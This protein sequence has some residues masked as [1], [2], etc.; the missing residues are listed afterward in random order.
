MAA[1][2]TGSAQLAVLATPFALLVAIA[3]AGEPPALEGDL[4]ARPRPHP[5][6]RPSARDARRRQPR[7]RRARRRSVAGRRAARQRPG[8]DRVLARAR[9]TAGAD[10]RARG[11]ALGRAR[12][13]SR[14]RPRERPAR[15]DDDRRT[16][17]RGGRRKGLR[18]CPTPAQHRRAAPHQAGPGQPGLARARRR[19][20]V[21]RSAPA[22][23]GRPRSQHQLARDRASPHAIR[24][25]PASGAQRGP[26]AVS[27]H[28]RGGATRGRGN[29]RRGGARRRGARLYLSRPARPRGAGQSRRG[30]EMAH[31]QPR[32]AAALSHPRRA[33][34][35]RGAAELP[36]EGGHAPTASAPPGAG[37]GDRADPTAGRARGQARCSNCAPAGTTSPSSRSRRSETLGATTSRVRLWRLQRDAL[38]SRFETLGISV[39]RCEPT[40]AGVELAIEEVIT[41]RRHAR[42]VARVLTTAAGAIAL[43][44][45]AAADHRPL[46]RRR[47][48]PRRC[49]C[50][51]RCSPAAPGRSAS[52]WCSWGRS[53]WSRKATARYQRRSTRERCCSSPSSPTGRWMSARPDESSRAPP[54]PGCSGSSPSWP[55]A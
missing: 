9:R 4:T 26:G 18:R 29:A 47:A 5:G 1:L 42:P 20:R 22:G 27:R 2:V 54:R 31:G 30:A 41:L 44:A 53:T 36:L 37:P 14:D 23:A 17:G 13:R 32:H 33:L 7:R 48:R 52:C 12:R 25:R 3:L 21:R 15:S 46:A 40:H 6:R 39:S 34:L 28:V 16:A 43:A 10:V 8:A 19:D 45:L 51:W 50:H 24:Q 11:A 35:Q 38:R 49:S 55:P